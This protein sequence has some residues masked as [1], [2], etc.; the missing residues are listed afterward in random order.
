MDEQKRKP[1]KSIGQILFDESK[2]LN[3]LCLFVSAH[4]REHN[5]C[6]GIAPSKEVRIKYNLSYESGAG[7]VAG[8]IEYLQN[9][10]NELKAN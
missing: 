10:I 2:D 1:R 9:K 5:P 8:Y 6:I 3:N 4:N 7:Y